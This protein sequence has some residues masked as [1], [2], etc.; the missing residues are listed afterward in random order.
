MVETRPARVLTSLRAVRDDFSIVNEAV[1]D[2]SEASPRLP[3]RRPKDV[4]RAYRKQARR[5]MPVLPFNRITAHLVSTPIAQTS[6][7][8]RI[9]TP[10]RRSP[11]YAEIVM[12]HAR[13]AQDGLFFRA[14]TAIDSSTS[15]EQSWRISGKA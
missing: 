11:D 9:R 7:P 6:T 15:G 5:D 8:T 1:R 3:R 10:I 14:Y 13:I 12:R 2:C 4:R